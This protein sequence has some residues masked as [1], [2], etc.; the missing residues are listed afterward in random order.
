MLQL[1]STDIVFLGIVLLAYFVK[2]ATGFGPALIIV[3]LGSLLIGP[4]TTIVLS[5]ILDALAG[6]YMLVLNPVR[7]GHRFWLGLAV[8]LTAGGVMGGLLLPQIPEQHFKPI[9]SVAIIILGAWFLGRRSGADDALLDAFPATFSI[10]DLLVSFIS[11]FMGGLFGISGPLLVFHLK[12]QFVKAVFRQTLVI[13]FLAGSA[14]TALTYLGQRLG[15]TDV[16]RLGLLSVPILFIGIYVGNHFFWKVSERWFDRAV[17]L[18]L[19]AS[20]L[21]L[22]YSI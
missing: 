4:H 18:L 13:V 3:P 7:T 10:L 6:L 14:S 21:K 20:G 19:L 8:A 9:L 11:G 15:G 17:G 16:I 5:A 1:N 22:I 12:R 2:G